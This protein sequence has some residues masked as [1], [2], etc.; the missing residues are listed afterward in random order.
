M[1]GRKR[2]QPKPDTSDAK[3]RAILVTAMAEV[4]ADPT[5][6]YA[7]RKT[8]AYVCE[9]NDKQLSGDSLRAFDAAIDEYYAALARPIQ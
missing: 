9:E 1:H 7:F 2:H 3:V 5:L 6:I 8:G 4:G